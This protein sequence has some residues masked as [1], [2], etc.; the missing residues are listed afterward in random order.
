M[1][2]V[3]SLPPLSRA[4]QSLLKAKELMLLASP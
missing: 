3:P 1:R 4:L 2:A